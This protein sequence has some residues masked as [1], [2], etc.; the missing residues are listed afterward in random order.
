[1]Q[2]RRGQIYFADLNPVA[3]SV[4]GGAVPML[5]IQ[6]DVGN[7]YSPTTIV[8]PITSQTNR[9]KLPTRVEFTGIFQSKPMSVLA[10]LDQPRT[11]DKRRLTECVGTLEESVMA[12]IDSAIAINFG[13]KHS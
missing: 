11:L 3:G 9:P 5:V 7:K 4:Q 2:V 6:N 8:A 1:M 10:I 12:Q 13:L